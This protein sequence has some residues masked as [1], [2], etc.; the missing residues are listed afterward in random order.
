MTDPVNLA[1]T[2]QKTLVTYVYPST[3]VPAR[4]LP[5]GWDE[6]PGARGCTPQRCAF[7]DH[8]REIADFGASV[9]PSSLA[10]TG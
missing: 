2:A 1:L 8:V 10:R 4:P 5:A 3:G 9:S 7:R 6:V